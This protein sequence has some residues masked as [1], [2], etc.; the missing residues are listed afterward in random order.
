MTSKSVVIAHTGLRDQDD[1]CIQVKIAIM[2]SGADHFGQSK[3]AMYGFYK[4]VARSFKSTST[5]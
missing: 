1:W 3:M 4:N 2:M 5:K